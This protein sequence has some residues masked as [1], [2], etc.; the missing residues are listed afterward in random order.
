MALS[1]EMFSKYPRRAISCSI[2]ARSVRHT[3]SRFTANVR[4]I[5][6]IGAVASVPV[7]ATARIGDRYV[8]AA[9]AL[10][11]AVHCAPERIEVADVRLECGGAVAQP[12]RKLLQPLGL[13]ADQCDVR[14]VAVHSLGGRRPN[15][16]R[17]AGD[18][19]GASAYVERSLV[20]AH[21]YGLLIIG[22]APARF[23]TRGAE[24]A[25]LWAMGLTRPV[26]APERW[27]ARGGMHADAA[28]NRWDR[29]GACAGGKAR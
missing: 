9:E 8:D 7:N 18:E 24:T 6:S 29:T 4:S 16:A 13:Q 23:P 11:R 26:S 19:H 15:A 12:R 17:G 21:A 27:M 14:T 20:A 2:T 1:E 5:C 10:D 22:F 3:P 28:H 25:V